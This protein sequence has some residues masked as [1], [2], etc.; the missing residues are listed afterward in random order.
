MF[1]KIQII[2]NLG[3]DAEGRFTPSGTAV[4][5]FSVATTNSYKNSQGEQVK[6]TIWFR[7]TVWGGL[8]E[9][10]QSLKKGAKVFVE[11]RMVAD[12]E[13]GNPRL[14]QR[15]DGSW[16]ASFEINGQT[17]KFLSPREESANQQQ[18]E[19]DAPF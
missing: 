5:S 14:Y 4:T 13:T 12:R 8:A 7:V 11:G 18:V 17:I 15:Q 19:D 2:G 1:Q 9:A 6:E 3:K 10:C 16:A